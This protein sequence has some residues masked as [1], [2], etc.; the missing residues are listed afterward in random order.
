MKKRVQYIVFIGMVLA[1]MIGMSLSQ[2][3]SNPTVKVA[4]LDENQNW[5]LIYTNISPEPTVENLQKA[6]DYLFAGDEESG[7]KPIFPV[8]IGYYSIYAE[9]GISVEINFKKGYLDLT[10]LQ[11]GLCEVAMIKTFTGFKDIKRIYIYEEGIP[12]PTSNR[13]SVFGLGREDIYL[14]FADNVEDKITKEEILYFIDVQKNKLAPIKRRVTREIY[15]SR[16]QSLLKEL[17]ITPDIEGL[18]PYLMSD[19]LIL[20]V[21]IRGDVCYVNF[22][23]DFVKEYALMNKDKRLLIYSIVNTLTGLDH[24]EYVQFLINGENP[25]NYKET[26]A[27]SKLFRKNLVYV[28]SF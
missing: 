8:E 20:D 16:E 2:K 3:Q 23:Q 17:T 21:K 1:W 19:S 22:N 24:V 9:D 7:L 4:L 15:V 26:E 13:T 18:V 10:D 25:E 5:K 27:L 12:I 11:K 28:N 6:M 14:S